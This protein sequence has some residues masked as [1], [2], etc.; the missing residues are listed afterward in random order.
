M[1]KTSHGFTLKSIKS[2]RN[3]GRISSDCLFWMEE[4]ASEKADRIKWYE[5]TV[6]TDSVLFDLKFH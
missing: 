6:P 2:G 3:E 1:A 4:K 5:V